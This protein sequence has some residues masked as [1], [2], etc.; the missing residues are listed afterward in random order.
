MLPP[1]RLAPEW[2]ARVHV[3]SEIRPHLCREI[4]L[5][6]TLVCCVR[7]LISLPARAYLRAFHLTLGPFGAAH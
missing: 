2:A 1:A 7:A 6:Y 3:G 4:G 5:D